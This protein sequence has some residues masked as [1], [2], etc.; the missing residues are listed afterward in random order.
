MD[1]SGQE[2]AAW[3]QG[4]GAVVGR[5]AEEST[6]APTGRATVNSIE[7][8]YVADRRSSWEYGERGELAVGKSLSGKAAKP[9]WMDYIRRLSHE[10]H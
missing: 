1:D 7:W 9:R 5:R 10:P 2:M 3:S 6:S 8:I 4:T